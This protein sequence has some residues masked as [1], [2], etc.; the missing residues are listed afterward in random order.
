MKRF[1]KISFKSGQVKRST[2]S[3]KDREFCVTVLAGVWDI[4]QKMPSN[5]RNDGN[6]LRDAASLTG[7]E[8]I[9]AVFRRMMVLDCPGNVLVNVFSKNLGCTS[10][11]T[12]C[13]SSTQLIN[14]IVA[15]MD[16]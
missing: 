7:K 10:Y 13:P 9:R 2:S 4:F 3:G 16:R 8:K 14:N 15:M 11:G 1:D 6:N 5:S 12:D